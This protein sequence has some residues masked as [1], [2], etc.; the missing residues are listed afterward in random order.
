M[1]KRILSLF[2]AMVMLLSLTMPTAWAAEGP[3]SSAVT[4]GLYDDDG[5]WS[6]DTRENSGTL[7]YSP[8]NDTTLNLSKT[9][10]VVPGND[11]VFDITL[12]VEAITKTQMSTDAAAVVLVIDTSGSMQYCANCGGEPSGWWGDG[13]VDHSNNC[14]NED[15]SDYNA[16]RMKAAK[17]ANLY[18]VGI[19]Q[20]T[21]NFGPHYTDLCDLF[22]DNMT[23]LPENFWD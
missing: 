10:A 22:I 7:S 4:D 1:K 17:D 6:E 3:E 9:A 23:Q 21:T 5:N 20:E 19:R 2:M 14:P 12:T 15:L 11:N 8:N 18:L 13:P 16:S